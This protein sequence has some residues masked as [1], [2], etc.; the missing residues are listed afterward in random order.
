VYTHIKKCQIS[1]IQQCFQTE[2]AISKT[3]AAPDSRKGDFCF[4]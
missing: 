4:T 1:D 2:L 3:D